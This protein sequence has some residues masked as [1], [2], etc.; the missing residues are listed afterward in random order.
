MYKSH[1]IRFQSN[2]FN[3]YYFYQCCQKI[4]ISAKIKQKNKNRSFSLFYIGFLENL[5]I[6][7]ISKKKLKQEK[8]INYF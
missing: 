6:S 5:R 4:I 1:H 2:K 7:I 8:K 3:S